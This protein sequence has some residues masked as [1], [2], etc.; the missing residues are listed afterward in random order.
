MFRYIGIKLKPYGVNAFLY[1]GGNG[2]N[3]ASAG[4]FYFNNGNGNLNNNLGFRAC[5]VSPYLEIHLCL[6]EIALRSYLMV[7]SPNQIY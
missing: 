7:V 5:V 2:S 4:V 3:G 1:R 6:T